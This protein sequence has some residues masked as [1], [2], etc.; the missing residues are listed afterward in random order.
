MNTPP[1]PTPAQKVAALTIAYLTALQA[2]ALTDEE[3]KAA[4]SLKNKIGK[5][6]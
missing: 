4:E 6:L 1:K 3:Y 5:T 2:G